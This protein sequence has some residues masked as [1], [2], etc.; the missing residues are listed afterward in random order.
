MFHILDGRTSFWQWDLGQK[1]VVHDDICCEVHFCNK[2]DDCALVCT[3]YEED[4]KRIVD[5]PNI[6]LQTAAT[7]R[8]Y[9]YAKHDDGSSTL[10]EKRL[11]VLPRSKPADYVYTETEVRT[12]EGLAKRVEA[13]ESE[14]AKSDLDM[15][16]HSIKNVQELELSPAEGLSA[17]LSVYNGDGSPALHVGGQKEG[18]AIP[19]RLENIADGIGDGDVVTVGQLNRAL[20]ELE[21]PTPESNSPVKYINNQ[22]AD[23]RPAIRNLE[24]GTYII[25]G[26]F[27]W[28]DGGQIVNFNSEQHVTITRRDTESELQMFYPK[29]NK[30]VYAC[31]TDD[32]LYRQDVELNKTEST[33]NRVT[34][35]GSTADDEHYPTEKAVRDLLMKTVGVV[36]HGK[37]LI[38]ETAIV[39][40]E[41]CNSLGQIA[42]NASFQRTDYILLAAGDYVYSNGDASYYNFSY[43]LFDLD[44]K[45]KSRNTTN[46]FTVSES[47]YVII[48]DGKSRKQLQLE[49]GTE[50]TAYE[51]YSSGEIQVDV[52]EQVAKGHFK[53]KT[54]LFDGDSITAGD[55]FTA[56]EK[57]SII[58][59][60]IVANTLGMNLVNH[61]I[62][63]ST[64]ASKNPESDNTKQPL[65]LRFQNYTEDAD[66]VYIAIGTNDFSYS[67][68][69]IGTME[70]R[71]DVL[72]ADGT[73][74]ATPYTFYGALHILC[75]G[76]L[77]KY[78]GKAIIFAT[79]IKRRLTDNYT[80]PNA[81]VRNGKTLKEYGEIIKE[82]CDWYSIPVIDMYSECNITPFIDEQRNAFFQETAG[83]THPNAAG[84]AVMARRV[85]A[86]IRGIVGM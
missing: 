28:Y 52:S 55:G 77:N 49:S 63:G 14:A 3:V 6:L 44:K 5:V 11:A 46:P 48:N 58:Y 79:P 45:F 12:Y 66:I 2:T 76:L 68:T 10:H 60:A 30:V 40:G 71:E 59:P 61:A 47:C 75:K 50:A 36:G 86:G 38:D 43:I 15:E 84:H 42:T 17:A 16:H 34:A 27:R 65:V 8:V 13:L 64:A 33:D 78:A 74:R 57:T 51:P 56:A 1:L 4:G 69:E 70:D 19:L 9:S 80:N 18:A 29:G 35:I 39:K 85:I 73:T 53:G 54:I 81:A 24:T 82:V 20:D 21:I 62:G 83:G 22:D 41:V 72:N 25:Q 32:S 7:I 37:N 23:N 67:Y 31:I 26:Y